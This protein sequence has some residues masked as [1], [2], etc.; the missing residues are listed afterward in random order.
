MSSQNEKLFRPAPSP[1]A[2]LHLVG[3]YHAWL[4]T[5]APYN[6]KGKYVA[7]SRTRDGLANFGRDQAVATAMGWQALTKA[8][9]AC[10]SRVWV[11]SDQH[12]DHAKICQMTGRPFYSVE[13]M[14]QALLS[15]AQAVVKD[16]DWLVFLGDLSFGTEEATAA[17]LEQCPGRKAIILGNHDL[18]RSKPERASV[19]SQFEAI[20]DCQAIELAAPL[21]TPTWGE[22]R[23]L[24]LTHYPLWNSWV[25]KHTLNLHGHIHDQTLHGARVN[26]S[27]EQTAYAPM[28][29]TDVLARE[30][31]TA[32]DTTPA[33]GGLGRPPARARG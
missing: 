23:I 28:R 6:E 29:L 33:S 26:L 22:L 31:V 20:A 1:P 9:R 5:Q 12:L 24:W 14:N 27:V 17:W 3:R 7:S 13:S 15:A 21:L 8:I 30:T 4:N 16:D 10:P 25:P 11:W 32:D 2:V 19:W 18:D